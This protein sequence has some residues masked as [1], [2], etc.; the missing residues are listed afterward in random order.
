MKSELEPG[1][2]AMIVGGFF[3]ENIGKIVTCLKYIGA[4][5]GFWA[6]DLW[7]INKPII[8]QWSRNPNFNDMSEN[9]ETTYMAS[10]KTMQRIDDN[11]T[12]CLSKPVHI[13]ENP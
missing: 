12:K 5:I 6:D 13:T 1:C 8:T 7:E 10:A 3:P 4:D 11:E 9:K 2:M